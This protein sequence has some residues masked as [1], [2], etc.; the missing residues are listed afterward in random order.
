MYNYT[1][2]LQLTL[3]VFKQYS[4]MSVCVISQRGHETARPFN[5]ESSLQPAPSLSDTDMPSP[6]PTASLAAGSQLKS[7]SLKKLSMKSLQ[8]KK[9]K[10]GDSNTVKL[11]IDEAVTCL[12]EDGSI[13]EELVCPVNGGHSS[14]VTSVMKSGSL[15]AT[16]VEEHHSDKEMVPEYDLDSTPP[17]SE[18]DLETPAAAEK[19]NRDSG[20]QP[21]AVKALPQPSDK[22]VRCKEL[23]S[24]HGN[25]K[26][27]PA[28]TSS[29][30]KSSKAGLSLKKSR[31]RLSDTDIGYFEELPSSSSILQAPAAKRPKV[32]DVD[33]PARLAESVT[34]EDNG[35]D[36]NGHGPDQEGGAD[37]RGSKTV[38]VSLTDI[39]KTNYAPNLH[40]TATRKRSSVGSLS[41]PKPVT[42]SIEVVDLCEADTKAAPGSTKMD[43]DFEM[44]DK[45]QARYS[46]RYHLTKSTA[47][48]PLTSLPRNDRGY[49]VKRKAPGWPLVRIKASEIPNAPSLQAPPDVSYA[50]HAKVLARCFNEYFAKLAVAQCGVLWRAKWGKPVTEISKV[51][52]NSLSAGRRTKRSRGAVNVPYSEYALELKGIAASSS[53]R[54]V[55]SPK[56][57]TR[58]LKRSPSK[59]PASCASVLCTASDSDS[60][61][62]PPTSSE[63]RKT[64]KKQQTCSSRKKL[65]FNNVASSDVCSESTTPGKG[66]RGSASKLSLGRK[67]TTE[68]RGDW[69]EKSVS[70]C[71]QFDREE[72]PDILPPRPPERTAEPGSTLAAAATCFPAP[73]AT[74]PHQQRSPHGS[75]GTTTTARQDSAD[76]VMMLDLTSPSPPP[77]PGEQG[78]VAGSG[79]EIS[80]GNGGGQDALMVDDC[81]GRH[82]DGPANEQGVTPSRTA[83]SAS[84]S[85]T[86]CDSSVGPRNRSSPPPP[87]RAIPSTTSSR[88]LTFP[89][90]DDSTD[91]EGPPHCQMAS[92]TLSSGGWLDARKPPPPSGQ[93]PKRLTKKQT[94]KTTGNQS[95]NKKKTTNGGAGGGKGKKLTKKPASASVRMKALIQMSESE[96]EHSSLERDRDE[97]AS[98]DE[99]TELVSTRT[100]KS[101]ERRGAASLS[102]SE[103]SEEE[104]ETSATPLVESRTDNV[105]STMKKRRT[106]SHRNER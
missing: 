9:D 55:A 56:T 94:S 99:A 106:S 41:R 97:V 63:K 46:G 18:Q 33:K 45:L 38:I 4:Y 90:M 15:V 67:S 8:M 78:G 24:D 62:R 66:P 96:S 26:Q 98:G 32:Q 84:R 91:E 82:S 57:S 81:V 76:D 104:R 102:D 28:A 1:D 21:L 100:A 86:D 68:Q 6:I 77:S 80:P 35:Q 61:F 92:S 83:A 23:K 72:S 36:I 14:S 49:L 70:P 43:G 85:P 10:K 5:P 101:T 34:V 93:K 7:V 64:Q 69:M 29:K 59:S 87:P 42:K 37:G 71:V 75:L 11:A 88:S 30:P 53:E 17:I 65:N 54:K 89:N 95:K 25:K 47:T 12:E 13:D 60:D 79:R 16:S 73:S 22:A 105:R 20:G 40:D 27:S 52:A 103:E 44:V 58:T 31:K 19:E 51:A 74:P 3:C 39:K 2:S 48:N 50:E